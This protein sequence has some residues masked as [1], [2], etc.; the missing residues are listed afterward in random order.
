MHEPIVDRETFDLVQEKIRSRK[1][2]DAWGNY[3]L[4]A[5]ILK[6]GQCGSA[7]N[8][9]RANQKGNAKIYTCSK[10]NKYG[11]KHCSQHRISYDTLNKIVLEE[12]RACARRALAGDAQG[13][14]DELRDGWGTGDEQEAVEQSIAAD[15]E[16]IRALERVVERLYADVT[17]GRI[18]E[19]NFT[20]I[21][22]RTQKEQETLKT[23]VTLNRERLDR[24]AKEQAD[25]AKF[26]S[27]IRDYA[28]IQELDAVTLNRLIEKIVVH[29]DRDGDGLRQTVEIFFNF[30]PTPDKT[31]LIR[32]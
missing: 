5:G 22:D 9:R 24:Q 29:E 19:D 16:R 31:T 11:V 8:I 17:A 26:A 12:I 14:A 23:R 1:R 28:D 7:L 30:N 13:A 4:F 21:L 20:N 15:T 18:S 32:E 2:P 3:S 25:S 10:Y 6:C 27:I